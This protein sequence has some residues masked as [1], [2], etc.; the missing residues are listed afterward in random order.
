MNSENLVVK[1]NSLIRSRYDYT[2]AELR[3]VIAVVS[4]IKAKDKD[5][6]E[7]SVEAKEYANL[8][9][10]RHKDEYTRLKELGDML[11]SKPLHIELPDGDFAK[12]NW[13]SWFEYKKNEGRIVCSF[14]PKLKPYLLD[15]QESFTRYSLENILRMK[16]VYSIRVY[17]LIKSWEGKGGFK[18]SVDDFRSMMVSE[19]K[20]PIYGDL[21]RR[22][23]NQSLQ[24]INSLT[25]VRVTFEEKKD[26][27][28]VTDLVFIIKRSQ[29]Q[30]K[31]EQ[32]IPP[33]ESLDSS[34]STKVVNYFVKCRQ[35]IQP[36][37]NIFETSRK[38]PYLA[39]AEHLKNG[40][41]TA[42]QYMDI[43]T[44]IFNPI[45]EDSSFWRKTIH[46]I[47]GLIKNYSQVEFQAITTMENDEFKS[48]STGIELSGE[49]FNR[50]ILQLNTG[51]TDIKQLK[52]EVIKLA[53]YHGFRLDENLFLR[54]KSAILNQNGFDKTALISKGNLGSQLHLDFIDEK[55]TYE[56]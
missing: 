36:T 39:M 55:N 12:A 16:S 26:G 35:D 2:L 30:V 38:N 53:V 31:E 32:L 21:K 11:M 47:D 8:M 24:E 43:I 34:E 14:H 9:D 18:I 29:P 20:Y 33:I 17:E 42:E 40:S 6:Q 56:V 5:F 48:V 44:W 51:I 49:Q 37:F 52:A 41:K 45:Y 28:K 54:I 22:V 27:R 15:L 46:S 25:D 50:I 4:M 13:F 19:N 10:T 7:Y 3:L 23:L 1:H